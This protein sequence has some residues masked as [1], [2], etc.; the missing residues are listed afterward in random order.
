M[1]RSEIRGSTTRFPDGAEPITGP[2][3]GARRGAGSGQG[4]LTPWPPSGSTVF[5]RSPGRGITMTLPP[6]SAKPMRDVG[7]STIATHRE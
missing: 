7:H 2:A 1:E 6:R 4:R 3:W 5:A